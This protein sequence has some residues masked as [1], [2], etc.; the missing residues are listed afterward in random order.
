ME[1]LET[2]G[3]ISLVPV[4]VVIVS[5]IITRRSIEPL[6]LGGDPGIYHSF[7]H[8]FS[9]IVDQLLDHGS[10]RAGLVLCSFCSQRHHYSASGK[11][12]GNVGICGSVIQV[13]QNTKVF[14]DYDLAAGHHHFYRR[15]SQGC[16]KKI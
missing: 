10:G 1:A 11:I 3:A 9:L 4:A 6:L 14:T 7:P 2:L 13:L 16:F 5:A 8:Q 12:R 15:L